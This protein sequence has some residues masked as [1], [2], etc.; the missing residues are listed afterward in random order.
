MLFVSVITFSVRDQRRKFCL[1]NLNLN[2]G[3]THLHLSQNHKLQV[4]NLRHIQQMSTLNVKYLNNSNFV[5]K[6]VI[7]MLDSLRQSYINLL[8]ASIFPTEKV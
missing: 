5:T 1:E 6:I 8:T 7:I 4:F 3:Q 2:S